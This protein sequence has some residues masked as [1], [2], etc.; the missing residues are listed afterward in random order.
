MEIWKNI[1]W[2]NGMYK[3]S[4]LWNIKSLY[5][6]KERLLVQCITW[7]PWYYT[8]RLC[9][10]WIQKW[11]RVH[12]L[13]AEAF[14]PNPENKKTVNH[15]DWNRLNNKLDN[16][17]RMTHSENSTHW[18]Y[19]NWR[20]HPHIWKFWKLHNRSKV[21]LQYKKNWKFIKERWSTRDVERE[22]WI[23]SKYISWVCR[24]IR[25]SASWYIWKYK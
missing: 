4:N 9:K 7:I 2:Y 12:R 25:K 10:Y 20:I 18:Y 24:W 14:I 6:R 16:L 15:K 11:I 5:F 22:L 21:V 23:N 1:K 8:V 3:V 13:V 19:H 17:E